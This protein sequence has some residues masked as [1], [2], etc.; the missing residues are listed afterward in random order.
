M[1]RS[2][3]QIVITCEHGGNIVP[4]KWRHLFTSPQA[5]AAL[6]SHRGWD[7][8]ALTTAKFLSKNLRCPLHFSTTT[9]LLVELNRSLHHPNLFSEF[10][11]SLPLGDQAQLVE[12][13]WQPHRTNVHRT[14]S[15]LIRNDKRV[16]H[17]SVHSFTPVMDGIERSTDIGLLYDPQRTSERAICSQWKQHLCDLAPEVSVH[18]NR[19]YKG[20]SD[21]FTTALRMQFSDDDYAGIELEMNQRFF[22]SGR[23]S[24]SRSLT[25][26]VAQ[27]LITLMQ[28]I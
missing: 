24:P 20:I 7:P 13:F 2:A 15:D 21:G 28:R 11:R 9:R 23:T 25:R 3:W 17:L 19:P 18:R 5:V 26:V 12:R 1:S 16:L 22:Q 27:T 14:I 10:S 8:G 4:T 6:D